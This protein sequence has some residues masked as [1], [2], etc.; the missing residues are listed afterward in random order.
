MKRKKL[1][2]SLFVVICAFVFLIV[3]VNH[4]V[5]RKT[6]E[7]DEKK[8]IEKGIEDREKNHDNETENPWTFEE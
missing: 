7:H 4:T 1:W 2:V 3:F 5:N 6:T 8:N